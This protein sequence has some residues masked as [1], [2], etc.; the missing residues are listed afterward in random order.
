MEKRV[1]S[2]MAGNSPNEQI[3]FGRGAAGG[4]AAG[5]G[6]TLEAAKQLMKNKFFG[7]ELNLPEIEQLRAAG[8]SDERLAKYIKR[9]EVPLGSQ[10]AAQFGLDRLSSGANLRPE[11]IK[12]FRDA[13]YS[14]K[15]IRKAYEGTEGIIEPRA[16]EMVAPKEKEFDLSKYDIASK[17]GKG[18]GIRDINFLKSQ[19]LDDE[20]IKKYASGLDAGVIGAKAKD[21]LGVAPT[22]GAGQPTEQPELGKKDERI[23]SLKDANEALREELK[24]LKTTE[25]QTAQPEKAKELLEKTITNITSTYKPETTTVSSPTMLGGTQVV[26]PSVM[27][28]GEFAP[29]MKAPI[30]QTIRGGGDFGNVNISSRMS[31]TFENIGNVRAGVEN[32]TGERSSQSG[33]VRN[34]IGGAAPQDDNT[35]LLSKEIERG[36]KELLKKAGALK[37]AQAVGVKTY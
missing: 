27:Y 24:G 12:Q 4:Y 14:N 18:F 3:M 13:G 29:S 2:P 31:P 22:Q 35:P 9:Q 19:G 10:A 34:V 23:Q 33:G 36:K 25:N 1:A 7:D 32:V 5:G 15:D 21:F 11:Y 26:S 20:A 16:A 28:A 17:G 37:G 30:T 6:Y 8:I